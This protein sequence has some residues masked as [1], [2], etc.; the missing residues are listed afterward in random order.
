M[1]YAKLAPL[2]TALAFCSPPT[3]ATENM[4]SMVQTKKKLH[5]VNSKISILQKTLSRAHDR[6]ALLRK[7][8]ATTE[9][10]IGKQVNTLHTVQGA[11]D[12]QSIQIKTA[13]DEMNKLSSQLRGQ[14]ELLASHIQARYFLGEYQPLKWV[15]NQDEPKKINRLLTYYQ[16]IIQSRQALIKEIGHTQKELQTHKNQLDAA[17]LTQQQLKAR[18]KQSHTKLAEHK[19]YHQQLISSLDTEILSKKETLSDFEKDKN[20]LTRLIQILTQKSIAQ[21]AKPFLN[22]RK[23]LPYPVRVGKGSLQR[24]NQGVTFFAAEGTAVTAVYPGKV[25]FSD[26]LKGYGLLMIIDHGH[27]FMTLYAHNQSLFKKKGQSVV[28]N[29]QVASIGHTGGIKQNGLY[30]EIRQRG[31]AIPPLEWLS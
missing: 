2:L 4:S 29:E 13:Q 18:I 30:F 27:G 21:N 31:K 6:R 11:I 24:M 25:V 19:Q 9:K 28:Q 23:K 26:W 3:S 12:K 15:I 8:L 22:M 20:N 17:L 16:Y 1:N 7:E 14:Q 10:E 5:Q